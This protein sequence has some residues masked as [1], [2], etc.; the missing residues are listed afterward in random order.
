[1]RAL[2]KRPEERPGNARALIEALRECE[3]AGTWTLADAESW[4]WSHWPR[5]E[6]ATLI[7]VGDPVAEASTTVELARSLQFTPFQ[8]PSTA[9][10]DVSGMMQDDPR[11][12][13]EP[14]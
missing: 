2:A 9:D 4:W 13:E 8:A 11:S 3:S 10:L 12:H 5:E 6:G 7:Q 14:E 1:M